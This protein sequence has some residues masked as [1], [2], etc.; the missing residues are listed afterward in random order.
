MNIMRKPIKMQIEEKEYDFILD[1]YNT[2]KNVP[3]WVVM[4]T[5][6]FGQLSHFYSAIKYF[7]VPTL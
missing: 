4:N 1:H 3:L 5:L 2:Y 7:L 6:T